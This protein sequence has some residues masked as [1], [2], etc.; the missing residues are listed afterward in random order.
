MS[1]KARDALV[2]AAAVATMALVG[3]GGAAF[4]SWHLRTGTGGR[5]LEE[6]LWVFFA[7]EWFARGVW[8]F[9]GFTTGGMLLGARLRSIPPFRAVLWITACA[10]AMAAVLSI[11]SD[12]HYFG[13]PIALVCV[14]ALAVAAAFAGFLGARI[15]KRLRKTARDGAGQE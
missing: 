1:D 10:V 15:G 3:G 6:T 8:V 5:I 11:L 14:A 13:L 2:I 12:E 9:A 4:A 7:L